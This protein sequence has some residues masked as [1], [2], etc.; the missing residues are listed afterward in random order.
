VLT[1]GAFLYCTIRLL[2][3]ATVTP[4]PPAR[5]AFVGEFT[6]GVDEV[7]ELLVVTG[8]ALVGAG[9]TSAEATES[10]REDCRTTERR[11]ARSLV[12]LLSLL[13]T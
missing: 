13:T 8:S 7:A 3:F 6:E 12:P 9:V 10:R 4:E 1:L 11:S 2:S 5:G